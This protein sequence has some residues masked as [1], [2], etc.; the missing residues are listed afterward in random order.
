[1]KKLFFIVAAC[2]LI[3]LFSFNAQSTYGCGGR[4]GCSDPQICVNSTLLTITPDVNAGGDAYVVV[5]RSADVDF[6]PSHCGGNLPPL[7]QDHVV[8]AP[9]HKLQVVVMTERRVPVSVSFG[10][11]S[12]TKS[13]P[14]GLVRFTFDVH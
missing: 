14:I 4:F 3:V 5:P 11:E 8:K 7:P 12:E 2:L 10:D 9:G 1:M 6:D 13:S